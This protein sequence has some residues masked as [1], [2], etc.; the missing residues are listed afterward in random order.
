MHDEKNVFRKSPV[1]APS[2]ICLDMCNLEREIRRI[3]KIGFRTLHVDIIDGAFSPSMPLGLNTV[4]QLRAKTDMIFDAHVMAVDNRYITDE[5]LDIGVQSM[6]C[7]IETL[8]HADRWLSRV[9]KHGVRAG[10]ALKPGTSLHE[11]DFLLERADFILLMLINPGYADGNDEQQV[12]YAR[13][14]IMALREMI[15]RQGLPTKICIDGRISWKDIETYSCGQ[16]DT[17][18]VGSI[19]MKNHFEENLK[20]YIG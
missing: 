11:L 3:E 15:E 8:S 2:L 19:C 13:R 6:C 16:V 12:P 18:V 4:R 1:L 9:R 5:L 17:F 10:L 20:K 7:H 14:K